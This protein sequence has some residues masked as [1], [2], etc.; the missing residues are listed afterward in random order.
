MHMHVHHMHVHVP[1][2]DM[3]LPPGV[4]ESTREFS[5]PLHLALDTPGVDFVILEG[6][7]MVEENLARLPSFRSGR[8]FSVS[9][10]D[11]SGLN[12]P[13]PSNLPGPRAESSRWALAPSG[14]MSYIGSVR[15]A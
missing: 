10:R 8:A 12:F 7:V 6:S 5:T 2:P 15:C 14:G 9:I 11:V 3:L 1:P 13:S 4:T